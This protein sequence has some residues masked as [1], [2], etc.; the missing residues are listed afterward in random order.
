MVL[1]LLTSAVA[2]VKTNVWA[3]I[4]GF[5]TRHIAAPVVAKVKAVIQLVHDKVQAVLAWIHSKVGGTPPSPPA[6]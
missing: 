1:E 2:F 4:V 5:V 3:I 6:S